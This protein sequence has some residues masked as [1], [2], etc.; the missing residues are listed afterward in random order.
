MLSHAVEQRVEWCVMPCPWGFIR[1]VTG[2]DCCHRLYAFDVHCNSYFPLFV[3][4]YGVQFF[5]SPLLLAPGFVPVVLSNLLYAASL[6]YYHYTQF[7]GYNGECRVRACLR[8]RQFLTLCRNAPP[9]HSHSWSEQSCSCTRLEALR[10]LR[11]LAYCWA[12]TRHGQCS[13]SISIK[14]DE[15]N[16]GK[17]VRRQ[18]PRHHNTPL[19]RRPGRRCLGY[20]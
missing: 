17:S 2:D 14:E 20:R 4:L 11:R 19:R 13:L 3:A 15:C 7:L 5:L 1:R 9:Q 10:C 12:S 6:S 8:D 18:C 16:H